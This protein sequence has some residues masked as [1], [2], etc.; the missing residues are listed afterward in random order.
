MYTMTRTYEDFNG[1]QRTED[2][3]FNFTQAEL[4]KMEL[5]EGGSL[6]AYLEKIVKAGDAEQIIKYFE[7]IVLEAY[8]HKT[9]DGKFY[10][11]KEIKEDFQATQAY[12]DIF[13]ELAQDSD[14]AAKFI[15]GIMPANTEKPKLSVVSS[16]ATE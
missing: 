11:S 3:H 6:S 1:Q 14:A 4:A 9:V 8:G 16:A 10:K 13:M 5:S 7:T 15:N 12:S 2:F